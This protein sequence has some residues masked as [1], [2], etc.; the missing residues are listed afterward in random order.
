MPLADAYPRTPA[1]ALCEVLH[2]FQIT[3]GAQCIQISDHRI[4][5]VEELCTAC[6]SAV[7]TFHDHQMRTRQD[8]AWGSTQNQTEAAGIHACQ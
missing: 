5:R 3:E 7:V 6:T 4:G 8:H 1:L 2:L